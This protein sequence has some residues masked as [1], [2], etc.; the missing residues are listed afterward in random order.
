MHGGNRWLIASRLI[1]VLPSRQS[2]KTVACL[3]DKTAAPDDIEQLTRE[4]EKEVS[5]AQRKLEQEKA[6]ALNPNLDPEEA[7]RTIKLAEL[8]LERL[9]HSLRLLQQKHRQALSEEHCT[10]WLDRQQTARQ[11]RDAASERFARL[12]GLINEFVATFVEA[13][14]ADA[15]VSQA[16]SDA[17][18]GENSRLLKTEEHCRNLEMRFTRSQVS[19][20]K[21]KCHRV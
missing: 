18:A 16:N 4:T 14:Q 2:E 9:Q 6:L 5:W 11:R 19:L 7:L 21:E 15:L 17:P 3:A 12:E 13:M 1:S 10:R 8:Q 20:M